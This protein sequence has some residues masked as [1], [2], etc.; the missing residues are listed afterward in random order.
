M[1]TTDYKD[2][3][4]IRNLIRAQQILHSIY[5]EVALPVF[6]HV[7]LVSEVMSVATI[8]SSID[9]FDISNPLYGQAVNFCT[10]LI[11]INFIQLTFDKIWRTTESR[12]VFKRQHFDSRFSRREKAEMR[13]FLKSLRPITWKIGGTFT[14]TQQSF[15][16]VLGD[17]ILQNVI[18]L[19]LA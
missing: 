12:E 16:T 3:E 1:P 19:L 5:A 10:G 18:N 4:A 2:R 17:V 6:S 15:L 14:I 9:H 8:Y 7:V 11:V 13:S